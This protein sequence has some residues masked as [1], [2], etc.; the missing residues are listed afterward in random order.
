MA[1][2][3]KHILLVLRWLQNSNSVSEEKLRLNYR[4]A[5]K[6]H[7]AYH[8]ATAAKAAAYAAYLTAANADAYAAATA[9]NAADAE[10]WLDR[11][12]ERLDKYFELTN[13]DRQAYEQRAK[14][15]SVLG[16]SNG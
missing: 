1:K 5:C 11:T 8:A 7:A 9:Y 10:I 3:N 15:L 16:V 6:A 14:H 4:A 13:E 12:K 2:F